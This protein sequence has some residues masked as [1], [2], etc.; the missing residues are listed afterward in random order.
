MFFA[1]MLE[2]GLDCLLYSRMIILGVPPPMLALEN[3][4]SY[5]LIYVDTGIDVETQSPKEYCNQSIFRV[6]NYFGTY[7]KD[8]P[9]PPV[10][11]PTMKST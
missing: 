2:Y 7:Y 3:V 8:A 4:R 5:L 11:V 1:I 9:Y 6:S 10:L